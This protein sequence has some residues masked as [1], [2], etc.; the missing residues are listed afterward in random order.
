MNLSGQALVVY[1]VI[2]AVSGPSTPEI[3]PGYVDAEIR[4]AHFN[5]EYWSSFGQPINRDPAQPML[6]PTAANSPKVAIDLT[7]EGLV[8][9][10]EPDDSFVNRIYARRIFGMVPGNILAGQPLDVRQGTR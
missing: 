1:R 9:W 4:M 10:Q 2:T 6:P 7:G 8:A 3:P 5:G